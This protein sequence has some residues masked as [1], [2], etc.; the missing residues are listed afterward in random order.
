MK[1]TTGLTRDEIDD[2]CAM[3]Q[4]DTSTPEQTW[5][6]ILGLFRSVTVALTYLRRNRCQAEIAEAYGVSQATISRAIT[7]VT[8]LIE[9]VLRAVVPTADDL[10]EKAPYLV[11]GTLLPCWSWHGHPELFSGKHK[12]TGMN[13]QIAA[14]LSGRVQWI[15]DAI[16]GSRH[17][18]ACLDDSGVLTGME[19]GQWIADKGYIGRGV[20]TPAR[21]PIGRDLDD[22]EKEFNRQ[23]NR[24]RATIERVIAHFKNWRI[25]HTDYRRPLNTFKATIAT[26]IALHFWATA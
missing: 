22:S 17:D 8:P 10:D 3:I 5:P 12:T 24:I 2:L 18:V 16:D 6:P 14:T 9:A 26:V 4:A 15:S 1:N 20:I 25:M 23:V 7:R 11:D 19:P 21:K 13:V